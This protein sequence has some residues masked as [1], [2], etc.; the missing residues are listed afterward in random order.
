[1][2]V[3]TDISRYIVGLLFIFSGLVKAV[4]PIGFSY[5][6]T[7]YFEEFGMHWE[8][9]L[10]MALPLAIFLVILE[11][12]L[13]VA[14]MTG[15][16]IRLTAWALLLLILFFTA[17]TFASAQYEI[18]K[19]CG[20]FGDAIPLDAWQ[21]F[22]K[23]CV[24]LFFV[25][26]IFL[27]RNSIEE[28]EVTP[29]H[30]V[31]S[32]LLLGFLGW[33]SFSRLEWGFTFYFP[34]VTLVLYFV[35]RFF[36]IAKASAYIS[37]GSLLVITLF[38]LYCYMYLPVKD[39]RAYAVG[40]NIPEQMIGVPDSLSYVYILKNKATGESEKFDKFPENWQETHEYGS[41][42]TTVV[43]PGIPAKI[44]DFSITD[45]YGED[46][47]QEFLGG[48]EFRFLLIEYDLSKTNTGVQKE[49]NE[50][51]KKTLEDGH[52]FVAL[53]ATPN[54]VTQQ[55]SEQNGSTFDYYFT[56]GTVLKT[57]I[58]ANPGLMLVRNGEVL[59][60]WHH[61]AFP[62]YEEVKTEYLSK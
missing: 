44:Q 61:N 36:G 8:F 28:G 45:P 31:M 49:V 42:E 24:L 14:V 19:S 6:L 59:G 58:R 2:K 34:L 48:D 15:Y 56:D 13:G 5:K 25:I 10:N 35:L 23:D 3:I 51:A 57:I 9:V 54:S 26:I 50:F 38:T 53:T 7:E 47:T 46:V 17:L 55:F 43:K 1:M 12:V 39:F 18:V 37:W 4:D 29:T 16:K 52:V 21:S 62:D 30:Y 20:C 27:S 11:I 33:L 60:K 32:A 40:K 41:Y 22:Y